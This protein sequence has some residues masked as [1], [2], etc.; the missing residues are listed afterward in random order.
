MIVSR[1]YIVPFTLC[2]LLGCTNLPRVSAP[3]HFS[4]H[5]TVGAPF[6]YFT[7]L[8]HR[9]GFYIFDDDMP[10]TAYAFLKAQTSHRDSSSESGESVSAYFDVT[11]RLMP[12]RN[13]F[14]DSTPTYQRLH[15]QRV[16]RMEPAQADYL[17][18]LVNRTH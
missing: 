11:G 3:Q 14:P 13:G 5:W 15:V 8:D 17:A 1:F 12:Y 18:S 16:L 2:L 6:S 9:Q 4:G 10:P 7:S